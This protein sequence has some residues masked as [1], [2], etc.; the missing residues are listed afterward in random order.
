L[1]V[2][3]AN[4]RDRVRAKDGITIGGEIDDNATLVKQSLS[5]KQEAKS[6]T[7][8]VL[9]YGG[10]EGKLQKRIKSVNGKVVKVEYAK[11]EKGN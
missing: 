5:S 8:E 6:D 1:W 4:P 7:T 3:I 9:I 10:S 11:K 2:R